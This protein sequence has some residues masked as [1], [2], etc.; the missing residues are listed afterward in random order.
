MN[1]LFKPLPLVG[2]DAA[3]GR[4]TKAEILRAR[5]EQ[6]ARRTDATT[7]GATFSAVLFRLGKE[8]YGV[9]LSFVQDVHHLKEITPLPGT[10]AFVLGIVNVR[11]QIYSVL[12]LKSLLDLPLG[13]AAEAQHIIMLSTPEMSF[14]IA[15]D[16]IAGVRS[17]PLNAL[18]PP[19]PALT[20]L[21]ADYVKGVT[22]DTIILLDAA[23]ILS[24]PR[25]IV[26]E[27]VSS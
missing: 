21:Q 12:N 23:V 18:L 25:L 15:V 14:G 9:E 4:P 1:Q 13:T 11:G 10:P 19:P 20:G 8:T 6:L 26:Q 16:A 2:G 27:T 22:T 5:A 17:I 7:S 24:D 3:T